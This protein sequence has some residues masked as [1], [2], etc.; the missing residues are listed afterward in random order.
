AD[1]VYYRTAYVQGTGLAQ[2]PAA[3]PSTAVWD[4]YMS[5]TLDGGRTFTTS[6]VSDAPDSTGGIYFGDI[7]TTGIFCSATPPGSGW[8]AD[9]ILY[10]DFGVAIGPDGGARIIWTDARSTHG[11][12]CV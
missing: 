7:C 3:A 11:G 1:V 5:Q 8:G 4:V 12:S 6:K 10:D 9:R 2:K